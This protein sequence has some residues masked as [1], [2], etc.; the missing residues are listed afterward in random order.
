M[1]DEVRPGPSLVVG[2]ITITPLER[3][4]HDGN[5][6]K[7]GFWIYVYKEAVGVVI[8]SP[9]GRRTLDLNAQG[10]VAS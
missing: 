8:D 7:D 6:G 4:K 3:V 9:A 5:T 1:S 2:E 10:M